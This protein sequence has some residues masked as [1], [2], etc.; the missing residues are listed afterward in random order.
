MGASGQKVE[1]NEEKYKTL[2]RSIKNSSV[3]DLNYS[4]PNDQYLC[5][6]CD[7]IPELVNIHSDNGTVVFKC[8]CKLNEEQIIPI[9]RYFELLSNS[10]TYFKSVCCICNKLQQN[11]IKKEV[12]KYCYQCKKDYCNECLEKEENHP[13]AHLI[14]CIPINSKNTRC[15]E[16]Y[17]AGP[18]TSF[19]LDCHVNICNEFS[20]DFHRQHKKIS[21]FKI[22]SHKKT[23]IEKNRILANIIKFNELILN[24]YEC[25]PDNY[26]HNINVA[27]LAASIDTENHREPKVLENAFK[28]LETNIKITKK[29]IEE[30]NKK[31]KTLIK[32]DETELS[33]EN[34]GLKDSDFI[35]FSK[36]SFSNLKDLNLSHNQL[37]DISSI[38]YISTSNLEYLNLN[39]NNIE[40]IEVLERIN[41]TNLKE[42]QLK[43]NSLKSVS[44]LLN[45]DL[46]SLQLL[47][48]DGN[49]DLDHSLNDFKKV[50]K[51][52][53][54][55]IIYVVK[56]YDDFNKKYEIKISE[57]SKEID[58]RESRKGNDI[59]K[60]LY[61]L[62][63]NHDKL[64]SLDLYNCDIDDISLLGRMTF[65]NLRN[66]DLSNNKIK[67][68]EILP[69]LK[70]EKLE[71]IFLDDNQISYITPLRYIKSKSL[72][73]VSIKNNKI[74]PNDIEVENLK[75]EFKQRGVTIK[76]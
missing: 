22:E 49:K 40:D 51:K 23:I 27:N 67:N 57:E 13:R 65:K 69:K 71:A 46:P 66:L 31:F 72:N 33:L 70:C 20:T 32:G 28:N 4:I 39:D 73:A 50:I 5:P 75:E 45:S 61:L 18:Y 10:N 6:F 38:K 16:H 26:Y 54:K 64:K 43:N 8:R 60:D 44:T 55:Q 2:L 63:S 37:K 58:L 35:L 59:L 34:K 24:T 62:S 21:F 41:L 30:F 7:R 68:I 74:I 29:S 17:K 11:Y 1:K 36:I 48:I 42:L 76:F 12:F 14:Q 52:F 53:T 3:L 19:C 47:R 56:T 25:F 9:E 15:L